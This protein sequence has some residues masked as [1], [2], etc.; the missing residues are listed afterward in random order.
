[1]NVRDI[2]GGEVLYEAKKTLED[3]RNHKGKTHTNPRRIGRGT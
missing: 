3:K 1:M 2:K